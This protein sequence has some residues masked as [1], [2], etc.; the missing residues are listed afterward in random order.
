[1]TTN[2]VESWYSFFKTY[3][4][5]IIITLELRFYYKLIYILEKAVI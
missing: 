4:K 2:I 5:G 3:V 1:M